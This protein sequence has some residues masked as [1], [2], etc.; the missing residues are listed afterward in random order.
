MFLVAA[1]ALAECITPEH[2]AEGRIYPDQSELRAVSRR[3]ARDVIREAR[4]LGLGRLITDEMIDVL[5]DETIWYP[6]YPIL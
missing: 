3:I 4:C 2:M 1:R 5:L 6:D